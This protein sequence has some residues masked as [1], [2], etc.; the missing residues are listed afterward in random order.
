VAISNAPER[1]V[2]GHAVFP[3]A[4]C[5]KCGLQFCERCLPFVV[6]VDAYCEVC[7]N[8]LLDEL[9]PRW[10]PAAGIM[11]AAFLAFVGGNGAYWLAFGYWS[12]AFALIGFVLMVGAAKLA[13]HVADPITGA[14][15]PVVTRRQPGSP[16]PRR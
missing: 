16:L 13:W 10:V 1:C 7:G 12:S 14:D 9:R 6:N 5:F 8:N 2:N 11:I 3:V 4:K 15:K